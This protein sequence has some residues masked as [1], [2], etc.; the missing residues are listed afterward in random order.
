V[1][2]ELIR[3]FESRLARSACHPDADWYGLFIKL[4]DDISEVLPYLNAE[5]EHPTDYRQSDG[6][7]LWQ[8]G[9]KKYA[10]RPHE[11]AIAPVVDNKEAQELSSGIIKTV[12]NIW[13][14]KDKITPSFERK[15]PLPKVLDIY[16]LL[17]R[18]NCKKCGLPT[19]MAFAVQLRMDFKKLSLCPHLSENDFKKV[20]SDNNV[21]PVA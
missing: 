11:I 8:Y 20:V 18:S 9:D 12:N 2:E 14:Q 17:P 1:P 13:K 19:C 15:K 10:F 3:S 4:Y 7:L 21:E 6:I 16:K 5:L